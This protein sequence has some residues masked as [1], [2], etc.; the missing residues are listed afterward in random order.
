MGYR[1]FDGWCGE[2]IIVAVVSRVMTFPPV[3]ST[4]DLFYA[5]RVMDRRSFFKVGGS[6][7]ATACWPSALAVDSPSIT[8]PLDRQ[9]LQARNRNRSTVACSRGLIATSQ[10]LASQAGLDL[11]K[12]GGS[13]VDAAIAANAV[14]SV[15]EPMSNGPG[16]DLFAIGW[17]EKT[18]SLYGL[19]ASGCSPYSW[20]L[21]EAERLGL[22][23]IEPHSPLSWTVPGCV[24]GWEA[25][26]DRYGKMSRAR[27]LAEAIHY[28]RDGFPL[29]PIV[30]RGWLNLPSESHPSLT[31]TFLPSGKPL[32]FG[33]IVRNPGCAA[34]FE[35]L[36]NEGWRSFY[37][38]S[39]AERIVKFSRHIGGRLEPRD[40]RDHHPEWIEPVSA[41]YRG[42][43]V[44]ELPPNGQ[45]IAA[46][47]ML[48]MLEQ[49]DIG[50]L[51]PNSAE[52]LHLF[53]EAKKLAFEDRAV[54]YADPQFAEVPIKEL[55]SKEYG[56]KRAGLIDPKRAASVVAAG[57]I[58]VA[59]DTIYLTAA[60]RD[61]NMISLIQSTYHG[62]GSRYVPDNLGFPLQNRGMS[63]SLRSQDRN[64]L[65]P[66][67][68]PFHT[69]I[70]G[71]VTHAGRPVLSFGVMGGDFQPQGHVQVLMNLIDFGM[72]PQQAGDQPRVH[73]AGSS[74]P[75]GHR[76]TDSGN[77]HLE[78]GIAETVQRA[79][80]DLGHRV[81]S[82]GS[83]FG[84]YQS[85]WRMDNPLRYFGGSDPRKDGCAI[86]Y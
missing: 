22:S 83:A 42:F 17:D 56:K 44:W 81:Q 82:G 8:V 10:P 18:Q 33:D 70:P 41:G 13:A 32:Q 55:I 58:P 62:W 54:Y 60:D 11:L 46:L 71:F 2:R 26:S 28:A 40:F 30:A 7:T 14:L 61:G 48:N 84:G 31:D 74:T 1:S 76:S 66:H 80:Q 39:I 68:R 47:Q 43:D 65:E 37:E 59:S 15:V 4:G 9:S 20:N 78:E 23:A 3:V 52:Q 67:K 27:L 19:N 25:L 86:G 49:Y 5:A 75:W 73:H 12:Q 79:L 57:K 50:S 35:T 85:I 21:Q 36:V 38:G 34:F 77:V 51:Q 69:I 29:S 63:F 24:S 45:G 6:A 64:R 53:L 72:S 16:G